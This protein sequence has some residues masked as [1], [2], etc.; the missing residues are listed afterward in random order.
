MMKMHQ[1]IHHARYQR[2]NMYCSFQSSFFFFFFRCLALPYKYITHQRVPN[3]HRDQC[4]RPASFPIRLLPFPTEKGSGGFPLGRV[5]NWSFFV[6]RG[7]WDSMYP[8]LFLWKMR[9][10]VFVLTRRA[11][12]VLF[13]Q[14]D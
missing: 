1:N 6:C 7:T 5:H 12:N 3:N 14:L 9:I 4:Y 8:V 2:Y 11:G 10:D 13:F